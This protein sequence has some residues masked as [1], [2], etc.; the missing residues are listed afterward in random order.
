MA[1]KKTPGLVKRAGVWHIDKRINGQRICQSTG[2][3]QLEEAERFLAR[4]T[5]EVRQASVYGVRP[6]RTFEQAAVKF[7]LENQHKRSL[8]SDIGR[9]K[10]LLPWIGDAF[11]DKIHTGTLQPWIEFRQNEG[12]AVGTIN[13]GLKVVRRILNLACYEWV[14]EHG[15]T[16]LE[17][18]PRI[19][20]LPDTNKRKPYPISWDEQE[21]LFN[22]LPAHLREMALFAVNTGCR[23]GEICGLRWDWLQ[24]APELKTRVFVIPGEFV[25]NSDDRLVVLNSIALGVVNRQAGNNKEFVFSFNGKPITRMLNS[26][27]LRARREACLPQVRVHDLKHTFGR[28]LRAAGVGFE[29]RQDLLGHRSGR[30]TTHYSAAELGRLLE[31]AERVC[32][33]P[34]GGVLHIAAS[35]YSSVK[36]N[37]VSYLVQRKYERS[38]TGSAIM[39]WEDSEFVSDLELSKPLRRSRQQFVFLARQKPVDLPNQQHSALGCAA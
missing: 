29:D 5:E 20:L 17:S 16:W 33:K 37:Y 18:V 1:R 11:I 36:E 7:V 2:T 35:R 31:A 4:L 14:D 28:R 3:G 30:I 8:H 12:V 39:R 27:W 19:K 25:K 21:T 34:E 10:L 24:L 22:L 32:S 13:H 6:S 23:D 26:A 9:I 15:L 38:L